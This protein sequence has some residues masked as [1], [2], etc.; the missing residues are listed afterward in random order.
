MKIDNKIQEIDNLV[1]VHV[2]RL[3]G[4]TKDDEVEI[5]LDPLNIIDSIEID[6]LRKFLDITT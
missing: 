5:V 4:L 2:F 1:N 3:Y 6:I